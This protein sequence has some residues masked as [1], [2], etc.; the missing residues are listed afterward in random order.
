[1]KI[2]VISDV[3][4]DISTLEKILDTHSNADVRIFLGDF[5]VSKLAQ[6]E[7]GQ[8]FDYVV[9][10]N[11]DHPGITP[12]SILTELDGVKILMAHGHKYYSLTEYVAKGKLAK[13]AKENGAILA[14]HGH[15]HV[16]SISE[17]DGVTVFNPG[18]PSFPRQGSKESYGI[19]EIENGKITRIENIYV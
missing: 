16:G 14:L 3:H 13:E 8:K 2:L 9:T 1:M 7:L 18:S 15:D 17:H 12:W 19:I 6:E 5:Q 10:G 11:T 4:G